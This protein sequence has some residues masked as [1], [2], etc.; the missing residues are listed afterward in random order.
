MFIHS[1]SSDPLC[2]FLSIPNGY[3]SVVQPEG[4]TEVQVHCNPGYRLYGSPNVTCNW[5]GTYLSSPPSCI[6]KPINNQY[7]IHTQCWFFFVKILC[8]KFISIKW[9]PIPEVILYKFFFRMFEVH[10][11]EGIHRFVLFIN[12]VICII[13]INECEDKDLCHPHMCQNV[14]GSYQCRCSHGYRKLSET[15]NTC[16]GKKQCVSGEAT[17]FTVTQLTFAFTSTSPFIKSKLH[18]L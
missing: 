8:E 18:N 2:P 4:G 16:Y 12:W 10:N 3:T 13:D 11:I 6:G 14:M 5:N 9:L 15:S 17:Q 1:L 7:C